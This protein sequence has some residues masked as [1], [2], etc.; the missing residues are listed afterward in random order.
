M[1]EE[2]DDEFFN[3]ADAHITLAN[4][5]VKDATRGKV[6]ASFMYGAARFNAWVAA[7]GVD[8]A[9]EL[10]ESKAEAIEYFVDAYRKALTEHLDEYIANYERYM[11]AG[12][13][14]A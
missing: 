9:D 1:A 7:C 14:D 11:K 10:Q 6:S 3:R 4:E 2:A 5:Q 8:S 13:G 12:S